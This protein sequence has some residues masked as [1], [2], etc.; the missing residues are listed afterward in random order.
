MLMNLVLAMVIFTVAVVLGGALVIGF[1]EDWRKEC[2]IDF[3]KFS[4]SIVLLAD[5]VVFILMML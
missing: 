4:G 1:L 5:L 2:V 3:I